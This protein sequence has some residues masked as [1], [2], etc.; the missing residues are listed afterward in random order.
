[1]KALRPLL[2]GLVALLGLGSL[3]GC[4]SGPH[5]G[6][7]RSRQNYYGRGYGYRRGYDGSYGRSDG[8]YAVPPPAAAAPAEPLCRRVWV[9]PGEDA[10]GRWRPG[11]WRCL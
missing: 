6:Y 8:R 5:H 7:Y 3:G 11:H 10:W 1:M 9:P 2:V 4:Y